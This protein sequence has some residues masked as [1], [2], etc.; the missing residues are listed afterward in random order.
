MIRTHVTE[1][2]CCFSILGGPPG[3]DVW[4]ILLRW[5]TLLC[6]Q[7]C[8][9]GGNEVFDLRAFTVLLSRCPASSWTLLIPLCF[10]SAH[11]PVHL[12]YWIVPKLGLE[13]PVPAPDSEFD[14][15]IDWL[16]S[17]NTPSSL[18]LR[19]GQRRWNQRAACGFSLASLLTLSKLHFPHLHKEDI[20]YLIH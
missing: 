16:R 14:G 12:P 20:I 4:A 15:G 18:S 9:S 13:S 10:S 3:N 6:L 8:N 7:N 2:N 1:V 17:L 19:D 5:R 11:C